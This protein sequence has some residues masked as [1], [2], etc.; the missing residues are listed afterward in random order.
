MYKTNKLIAEFMKLP[1]GIYPSSD[2]KGYWE[3]PIGDISRNTQELLL[4]NSSWDWLMPVLSKILELTHDDK[5][6][7]TYDSDEYYEILNLIPDIKK[8][9]N[10]IVKFI[11]EYN[12]N[13]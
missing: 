6:N 4:Y 8:T 10:G 13:K 7:E 12:K 9:Y 3:T 11:E 5:G 1:V 2:G